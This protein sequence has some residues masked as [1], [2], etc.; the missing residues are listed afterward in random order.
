[1]EEVESLVE[2]FVTASHT[3]EELEEEN[4]E[5][6]GKRVQDLENMQGDPLTTLN[7]TEK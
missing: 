2:R 7:K 3:L 6:L 4:K 1:M 5:V